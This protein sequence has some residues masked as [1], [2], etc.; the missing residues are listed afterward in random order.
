MPRVPGGHSEQPPG[1]PPL[2]DGSR[3]LGAQPPGCFPLTHGAPSPALPLPPDQAHPGP[4]D[5]SDLLPLNVTCTDPGPPR[6]QAASDTPLRPA[7]E[8][9]GRWLR[10]GSAPGDRRPR[11]PP[12]D[13]LPAGRH[14]RG[15]LRTQ[16]RCGRGAPVRVRVGVRGGQRPAPASAPALPRG[17]PPTP[18]PPRSRPSALAPPPHRAAPPPPLTWRSAAARAGLPTGDKDTS[19]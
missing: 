1:S 7:S 18:D 4:S 14:S 15:G 5:F 19:L 9:G 12:P 8:P 16:S 6:A 2:P 11:W 17:C 3:P 10:A 13:A